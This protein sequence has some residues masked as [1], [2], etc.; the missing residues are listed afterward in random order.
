MV[1][2]GLAAVRGARPR[3]RLTL[4]FDAFCPPPRLNREG[5]AC[6][7][8]AG[9]AVADGNSY[10]VAAGPGAKL[11]AT[12]RGGVFGQLYA[13]STGDERIYLRQMY[14]LPAKREQHCDQR[15]GP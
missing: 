6:T 1:G 4:D 15:V 2:R 9:E 12:A 3:S 11:P 13:S 14:D 7:L 8:L 5:A 10:R